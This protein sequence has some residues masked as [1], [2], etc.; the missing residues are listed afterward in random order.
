MPLT[1]RCYYCPFVHAWGAEVPR[2]A[3]AQLCEAFAWREELGLSLP[4]AARGLNAARGKL[5][6]HV[7][8]SV[9]SSRLVTFR[10]VLVDK[11]ATL[12]GQ[13]AKL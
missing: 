8:P 3:T 2:S 1:N 5:G 9:C 4:G 7:L 10:F 12:E 11:L 13:E 6:T